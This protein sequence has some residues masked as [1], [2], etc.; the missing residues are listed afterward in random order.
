MTYRQFILIFAV[1]LLFGCATPASHLNDLAQMHDFQRRTI[2]TNEF[3]HL[4]YTRN[5]SDAKN[6]LHIYL[7]GDGSPWKYRVVTMPDPTPRDPLALRLMAQDKGPTAYIGRPCYNGA[8]E[9]PGCNSKLWTSGRYSSTVVR[10]MSAAITE[11]I[12]QYGFKEV[13]LIGHSGGGALAMLIAPRIPQVMHIVTIAANLDIDAWT[14]HHN[15]TRLYTS[16]NPA[17]QTRIPSRIKQWHLV[18]GRDGVVPPNLVTGFIRSQRNT[19]GIS[20]DSFSHSC[21]WEKIWVDVAQGIRTKSPGYL[22]GRR[23]KIPKR[24]Y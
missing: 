8:H 24:Q 20:V 14:T 10:S 9:D 5:L 6:V 2:D 12:N 7:E 23:F 21:C 13:T 1:I 3:A 15:Y 22:P 4:V 11:L 17:L 16:L 18:G 19:L